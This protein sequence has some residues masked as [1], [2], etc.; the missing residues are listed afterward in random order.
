MQL[1][2]DQPWNFY[3]C[4]ELTHKQPHYISEVKCQISQLIINTFPAGRFL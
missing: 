1:C 3:A 4:V 2:A